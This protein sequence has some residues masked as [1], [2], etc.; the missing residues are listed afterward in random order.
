VRKTND[1]IKEIADVASGEQTVCAVTD[2]AAA[3]DL[4]TIT[5]N[6]VKILD[7][8][9]LEFCVQALGSGAAD[10]IAADEIALFGIAFK[11]PNTKLVAKPFTDQRLG[12]GMKQ[13]ASGDRQGFLEFVNGALLKIVADRTWARLYE[14]HITQLTGDKKQLPTD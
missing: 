1:Q 8:S 12:I 7:L 6:R 13:N 10:A 4:R 3:K 5:N 2:S 9:S 11:D 14:K